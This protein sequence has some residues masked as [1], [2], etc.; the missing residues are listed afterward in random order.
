V[1][2]DPANF[3]NSTAD[4]KNYLVEAKVPADGTVVYY[5]GFGWSKSGQFQSKDDWDRYVADYAARLQAPVQVT[6]KPE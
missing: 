5:A 4:Q 3:V 2:L 6:L 1:I